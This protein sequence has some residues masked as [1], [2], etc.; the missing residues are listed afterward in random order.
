M[1]RRLL[2]AGTFVLLLALCATMLTPASAQTSSVIRVYLRRLQI[3]DSARITV[4]GT[5]M[6]DRKSVV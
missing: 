4:S 3:T 5:Y 6:L 2:R 1:L